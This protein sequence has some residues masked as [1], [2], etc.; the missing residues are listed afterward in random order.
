MRAALG[1]IGLIITLG[2]GY[3][4]YTSQIQHISQ[5]KPLRQQLDL[6][7]IKAD[8]LSLAQAERLYLATNGSYAPLDQLR[9]SNMMNTFP[10][11]GR[12]GYQYAAEVDGADHF[13]ITASPAD[14]S[15]QGLPTLSI[16]ETI[17]VTQ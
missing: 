13:Q 3:M 7:A 11:E 6:V 16:D 5:D 8:L 9:R 12:S 2:I 17:N 10:P 1:L 15:M 4:I 14:A